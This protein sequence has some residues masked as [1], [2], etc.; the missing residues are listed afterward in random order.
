M[1]KVA[2]VIVSCIISCHG[3]VGVAWCGPSSI[4]RTRA[5]CPSQFLACILMIIGYGIIAV[6]TGI[7]SYEL[8]RSSPQP[9]TNICQHCGL[10]YHDK[11]ANYCK[12]CGAPL[13]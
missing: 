6:P 12:R 11:D 3:S 4:W 1:M 5:L 10:Q 7:V 2:P 13:G 8:A 9:P